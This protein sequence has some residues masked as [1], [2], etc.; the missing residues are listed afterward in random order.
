MTRD[1]LESAL[2]D[3]LKTFARDTWVAPLRN[4]DPSDGEIVLEWFK[5]DRKLTLY[6]TDDSVFWLFSD[7][8]GLWSGSHPAA[9]VGLLH[10]QW[11]WLNGAPV[12]DE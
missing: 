2:L 4:I 3:K 5:A 7:A 1:E 9:D 10:N 8:T 12:E 6:V 11:R